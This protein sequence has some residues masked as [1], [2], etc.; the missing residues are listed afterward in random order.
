LFGLDFG[1]RRRQSLVGD[2]R[3]TVRG[4]LSKLAYKVLVF[5]AAVHHCIYAQ[6]WEGRAL[7]ELRSL[8]PRPLLPPLYKARTPLLIAND[9]CSNWEDMESARTSGRGDRWTERACA[10]GSGA[11][12]EEMGELV[13]SPAPRGVHRAHVRFG[14]TAVDTCPSSPAVDCQRHR[15]R[16][17]PLQ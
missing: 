1:G 5:F 17:K 7:L 14:D 15:V 11:G 3:F 6:R 8:L 2:A 4:M 16:P 12:Q 9:Y 13:L 10:G